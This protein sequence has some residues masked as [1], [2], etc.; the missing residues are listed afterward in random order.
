LQA[1]LMSKPITR[2]TVLSRRD[3]LPEVER[4]AASDAIARRVDGLLAALPGG[5]IV[6]LYA[7][8]G[9]EVATATLD[10]CARARGLRVVYPRIVDGDRRLSFHE[11]AIGELAPSRFGLSEPAADAR[12]VETQDISAFVIPGLAFDRHGWRVG[13]GRGYYDATLAVAPTARRIGVAFEC[14]LVDEVP[15]DVHDARL[16]HVVT[17]ANDYAGEVD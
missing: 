7:P 10:A 1:D 16:H 3:K 15:R 13:W 8:K 4:R 12:R 9:T 14:Q 6:A 17:E 2:R 11:V 5:S